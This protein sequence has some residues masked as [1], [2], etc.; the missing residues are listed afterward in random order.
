MVLIES[1]QM[2]EE[3]EEIIFTATQFFE[4]DVICE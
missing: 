1:M 2:S 4:G 3:H